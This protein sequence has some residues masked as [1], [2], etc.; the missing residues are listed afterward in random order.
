MYTTSRLIRISVG[1]P[2][3]RPALFSLSLLTEDEQGD[4]KT[5]HPAPYTL[6]PTPYTLYP[7]PY[8]LHP[9]PY[10]LHSV[11]IQHINTKAGALNS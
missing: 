6:H 11:N 10:T 4:P 3:P 5:L 9:T 7:T 2:P 1:C 8:T